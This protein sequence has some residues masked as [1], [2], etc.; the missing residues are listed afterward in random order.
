MYEFDRWMLERPGITA[1]GLGLVAGIVWFQ[2]LS[3]FD[4]EATTRLTAGVAVGTVFGGL[5]WASLSRRA[6]A[7]R[8]VDL[9]DPPPSDGDDA[10]PS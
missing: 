10:A 4:L 9:A 2:T 6:R 3:V 1:A 7:H 5:Q 8:N